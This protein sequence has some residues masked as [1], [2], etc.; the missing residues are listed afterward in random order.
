MARR[1]EQSIFQLVKGKGVLILENIIFNTL[2]S[3]G[4]TSIESRYLLS[5]STR[6]SE[7]ISVWKDKHSG[8]IYI[9]DFYTGDDTYIEGT[10]REDNSEILVAGPPNYECDVDAE[11]RFLSTLKFISGKRVLDFGCG[12]G[13]FLELA[14]EKSASVCGVELQQDYVDF[15]NQKGIPCH[16]SLDEIDDNSIDVCVSFHVLEHLPDPITTLSLLKQKIVSGGYLIVEV[17]HARDFLLS[18]LRNLEFQKFTLWS[19]HLILHTRESLIR[20]LSTSGFDDVIVDG[21]QRYPLSNHLGWLSNGA[22]GGHKSQMAMIDSTALNKSYADSLARI[23]ATD[24]LVA[25]GR[26]TK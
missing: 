21:V 12:A 10:Y 9:D 20:F 22:P 7:N 26:V 17:P 8:L 4:L 18:G 25:V 3:L 6:D 15:L 11:R 16:T 14:K 23:D 13:D 24:T 5:R 1:D 2:E 19:Q